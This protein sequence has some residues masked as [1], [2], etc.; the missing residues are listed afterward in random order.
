MKINFS[1]Q[2]ALLQTVLNYSA[3]EPP[4]KGCMP[5]PLLSLRTNELSI[6]TSDENTCGL[7]V[8]LR[9]GEEE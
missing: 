7:A 5:L 9:L 8:A 4:Q 1:I 2:S 3:Q 6:K